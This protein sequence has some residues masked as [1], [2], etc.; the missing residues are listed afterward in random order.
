MSDIWVQFGSYAHDPG[1]VEYSIRKRA[2]L[3]DRKTP[4]AHMV[5]VDM[6]GMLVGSGTSEIE[7]KLTNM[8]DAYSSDNKDFSIK[9]GDSDTNSII[10][11]T[12]SE[13]NGG[14]RV[15]EPVSYP[16]NVN[17]V[18]TTYMPYTVSLEAEVP[19][20]N[21][22]TAIRSFVET[23]EFAGGGP[24]RGW[25]EPIYGRPVRQQ[26]KQQTIYKA[27]QRGQAVGLYARP[28]IPLPIWPFALV[29]RNPRR[30][31]DNGRPYGGGSDA[32]TMDFS[33]SWQYE[34]ESDRPLIGTP[35]R[36][37]A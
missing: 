24:R 34:F 16:S 15:V 12:S 18:H 9:L 11:I 32:T 31:I 33:V 17:A 6:A 23:L 35:H 36:W 26:L 30:A 1:E 37:G 28:I 22:A 2:L 27:I 25:L 4:Y 3:T 5:R 21:P 14:V 13:T 20:S 10:S 7:A 29:E 19:I 8:I